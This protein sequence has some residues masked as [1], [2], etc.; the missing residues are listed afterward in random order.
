MNTTMIDRII[1]TYG[2]SMLRKSAM[3]IRH[4]AGVFQTVLEGRGFDNVLEIGTYRGVAA[5]EMSQYCKTVTTIDL[6]HGKLEQNG[7]PFDRDAFWQSL[8]IDNIEFIAVANDEEKRQVIRTLT[9]DLAFID[10]GHK[11]NACALDF[12][13]VRH[14][15]RVLFHDYDDSHRGP[16]HNAVFDFVNSLP[17]EEVCK[18]DIFALWIADWQTAGKE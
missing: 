13:L 16:E 18:L 4:G 11:G 5:A 8:G 2:E 17:K 12:Q 9:F 6:A 10:G 1:G 3:N 14:C 15:G 7:T